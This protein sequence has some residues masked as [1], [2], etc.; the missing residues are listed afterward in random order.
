[1]NLSLYTHLFSANGRYY[2]FNS[3]TLLFAEISEELY[4]RLGDG[5][6][7]D[8]S[9]EILNELREQQ[10]I[11][12]K[13]RLYDYYYGRLTQSLR[14]HFNP[15]VLSLILVPTTGC[16]LACPYCFE[17]KKNPLTMTD[18][19]IGDLLES[20]KNNVNLK[21]IR[22]SWYG[23]EPLMAFP[24]IKK[25]WD[26]LNQDGMPKIISHSIVTN[27]VLLDE[28]K[29]RFFKEAK[30]DSM[31]ITL[32]GAKD[33]HESLRCF[34]NGGA[35]TYNCILA[36]IDKVVEIYPEL[37]LNIRVN[38]DHENWKDYVT[39][40]KMLAERYPNSKVGAYEGYLRIDNADKTQLC[41]PSISKK[42]HLDMIRKFRAS[43]IKESLFP[44][45]TERG[46]MMQSDNAI[47][48]GPEGEIYKCWNDVS[49][50]D[51]VTGHIKN[52][53]IG[54]PSLQLRYMHGCTPFN[55]ECREC[56]VFPI[57]DGGCC[58]QRYRN[59]Y[60][61]GNYDVC[62]PYKDKEK[63]KEALLNGDFNLDSSKRE[64]TAQ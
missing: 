49:D 46:C 58:L 2:L 19:T 60:E 36:N 3:L 12:E 51:R 62:S 22:L 55:A 31:Q 9:E 21:E 48:V 45:M 14:K 42:E 39:V 56:G 26:G 50:P 11:M 64:E 20:I 7:A 61:G 6:Y 44:S 37:P 47:I 23:G 43:G 30:L 17:P 63:L 5:S 27:G 54:N 10:I 29:I 28:E 53:K 34:K 52:P 16:N 33:R 24:Q 41:H 18:E 32:D 4:C 8:Y 1:M 25:I 13:E 38:I 40:K 15:N 59:M 35:G 57:C